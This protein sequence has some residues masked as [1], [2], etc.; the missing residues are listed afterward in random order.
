[1]K[2]KQYE[3]YML[4]STWEQEH[5]EAFIDLQFWSMYH[6]FHN[7]DIPAYR[8]IRKKYVKKY[9]EKLIQEM[10][11]QF[12]SSPDYYTLLKDKGVPSIKR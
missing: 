6:E 12:V 3:N 5:I 1:M 7:Q 4:P 2:L 10:E 8:A 9:N 11:M